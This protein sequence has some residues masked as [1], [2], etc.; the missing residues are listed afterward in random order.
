[1]GGSIEIGLCADSRTKPNKIHSSRTSQIR[2]PL[3]DTWKKP[4]SNN[5]PHQFAPRPDVPEG[6]ATQFDHL[7]ASRASLMVTLTVTFPRRTICGRTTY[8][9]VYARLNAR[10]NW[11]TDQVQTFQDCDS[12]QEAKFIPA[13]NARLLIFGYRVRDRPLRRD[14]NYYLQQNGIPYY[15]SIL[16][17]LLLGGRAII[18]AS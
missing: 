10:R 14:Q 16:G 18:D 11:G 8:N 15:T 4:P 6:K 9:S 12:A 1:M 2:M 3:N 5:P 13:Q 17:S 7:T